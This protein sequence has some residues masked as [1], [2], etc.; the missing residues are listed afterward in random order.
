MHLLW[1]DR[2]ASSSIVRGVLAS[3]QKRFDFGLRIRSKSFSERQLELRRNCSKTNV[4]LETSQNA[5]ENPLELVTSGYHVHWLLPGCGPGPMTDERQCQFGEVDSIMKYVPYPPLSNSPDCAYQQ[6]PTADTCCTR[7]ISV[8][9]CKGTVAS[10]IRS[11][12]LMQP[13]SVYPQRF[14]RSG[15]LMR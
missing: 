11:S 2:H 8:S 12:G 13:S 6:S 5:P 1:I 10:N 7:L 4:L 3:R 15:S 14:K 9:N